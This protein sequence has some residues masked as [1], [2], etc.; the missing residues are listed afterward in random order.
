[1]SKSRRRW[2]ASLLLPLLLMVPNR[3]AQA[4]W[5]HDA[6]QHVVLGEGA[7]SRLLPIAV[8][9]DAGGAFVAWRDNRNGNSD[10]YLQRVT[11]D[12]SIAP[13]WPVGGLSVCTAAQT[14]QAHRM[15]SDG[16]GGVILAWE[17]FRAGGSNVD[18]Y[19][20]RVLGDGTLPGGS[21]VPDGVQVTTSTGTDYQPTICTDGAGGAIITYV[22]ILSGTD[23]DLY[24]ARVTDTG[25]LSPGPTPL[26]TPV[27]ISSSPSAVS[28]G[29]GVCIVSFESNLSG[30][31][32]IMA[33]RFYNG[34]LWTRTV[35]NAA[36]DQFA[37][38]AVSDGMGGAFFAWYDQRT[39]TGMDLYATR[40]TSSGTLAAGWSL[41][42]SGVETSSPDADYLSTAADGSGGLL[43]AWADPRFGSN[44]DAFGSRLLPSGARAPGWTATGEVLSRGDGHQFAPAVTS[45]GAGGMIATWIDGRGGGLGA[46]FVYGMRLLWNGDPAPGWSTDGNLVS[47]GPVSSGSTTPF[48]LV[49]DANGDAIASFPDDQSVSISAQRIDR[50]G[51]LGNAEPI[52][53]SVKDVANDQGGQIRLQW[54]ASYFDAVPLYQIGEYWVWRQTPVSE[55]RLAVS[56]GGSWV[57][58]AGEARFTARRSAESGGV[59]LFRQGPSV[60]SDYAWEFVAARPANASLQ[61]SYVAPSVSDSSSAG[62]PYTVFMIE[63]HNLAGNA[64]WQSAPDS[65][66]SL[67]NLPPLTP[68]PFT[69]V[70]GSGSTA[71]Q[72]G[73]NHEADLASYR[74]HRGASAG[75]VPGPENLISDQTGTSFV[76]EGPAGAFYK[77]A[78][79][80]VHGNASAYAF[81]SPSGTVDVPRLPAELALGRPRPNPAIADC[82]I[83]F[84]LPRDAE[85]GIDVFDV[86]GRCVRELQGGRLP[87]GDHLTRWDGRDASGHAV[88]GGLYLVRMRAEG[89]TL[90]RRVL[91]V[92]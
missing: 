84:A 69:G 38:Q 35:C 50:F 23:Y 62:N 87:A 81:L 18:V 89:R 20:Q 64:F 19:V 27:E 65:C 56:H 26:Y 45:D 57:D 52:L 58:D 61:Y 34:P 9:D 54:N 41:N 22:V 6:L 11:A 82:V 3:V 4:A 5:P 55:A 79:V 12:G 88:G 74:L 80:D 70:Y 42:G 66:Y 43:V 2:V 76:D 25:A 14:Q 46:N 71:L 17:D 32:D 49:T 51:A 13:G 21:W 29:A 91:L 53:T 36:N 68:S 10:I 16:A 90:N 77:L 47:L 75:F 1:M 33:I 39:G 48:A 63:A 28:D 30:N 59:R 72:W 83:P 15:I 24:R 86:S 44:Y 78:A 7:S 92:R 31:Y 60:L 67:D 37:P 8:A 40:F 73:T 85:V